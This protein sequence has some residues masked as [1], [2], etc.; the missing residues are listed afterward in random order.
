MA[1]SSWREHYWHSVPVMRARIEEIVRLAHAKDKHV[2]E[3][4]CNEGFV[5]QALIE[6]GADVLSADIDP[7]MIAKA[8]ELFGIQA[9]IADVRKLPFPDQHFD[10]VV[11]GE[12]LEHVQNPFEA[13]T[14]LFRV[15]RERVVVSLPIGEYW[16]G[17]RT[18][19]WELHG[20]VID[21]DSG[22]VKDM[23]KDIIV[24]SWDRRRDGSW[25]DIPP[26]NTQEHA[27]QHGIR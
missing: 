1:L 19:I 9:I 5:S 13:M 8:K 15:A 21:H 26:F 24:M 6:D 10:V 2:L 16:M 11:S 18:H 4:G 23:P 25:N 27:R 22:T 12:T 3:I 20:S 17:E 14:E 7:A